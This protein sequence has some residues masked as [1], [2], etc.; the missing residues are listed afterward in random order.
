[1]LSAGDVIV[2]PFFR[3]QNDNEGEPRWVVITEIIED[4]FFVVPMTKKIRQASR[5]QKTILV[6]KNSVE[7]I[8]IGL[9]KNSLIILDRATDFKL[10]YYKKFNIKGHCSEELLQQILEE[11]DS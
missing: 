11:I 5:Y 6:R 9:L 10:S 8:K 3:H 1:M 2:L 4:I 7:G